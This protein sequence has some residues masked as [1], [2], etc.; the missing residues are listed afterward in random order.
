LE[1]S[2]KVGAVKPILLAL[3]A[4]ATI[5]VAVTPAP[6]GA[7][8]PCRDRIYNQW[9]ATGKIA[10]NYPLACYRDALKHIPNDAKIYSNLSDD[11]EAALQ[12]ARL[13]V[14]DPSRVI[15]KLVGSGKIN[16]TVHNIKGASTTNPGETNPAP[17]TTTTSAASATTGGGSGLPLPI[18]VLGG[19]AIALAAAGA[20]GAGVRY[21]R[22]RGGPRPS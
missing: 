9:Y 11:I 6:A 1:S 21:Y 16:P 3:L 2:G 18:L 10:T 20:I 7:A 5:A 17:G 13:H 8:P 4:A 19:V 22:Q 12:Q 15:P 14:A